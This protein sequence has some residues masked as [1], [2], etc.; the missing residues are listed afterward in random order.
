MTDPQQFDLIVVGSGPGGQKGAIAAAKSGARVAMVESARSVGGAC[1]HYGT[2]P[3][4]TLRQLA[5]DWSRAD[6]LERSQKEGQRALPLNELKSRVESVAVQLGATVLEQLERNG[7]R[8]LRG[9]GRFESPNEISVTTPRGARKL[10]RAEKILLA[11]GSTPRSLEGI[12]VDHEHV[13]D[14]DSVLSLS[15]LPES[16][17]VLGGGVIACEYA[18]MFACMG[19][20]VTILDRAPRPLGFL[21][22]ELSEGFVTAFEAMGGVYRAGCSPKGIT[23]DGFS[24]NMVTLEDGSFVEGEKVMVALGRTGVTREL[25]LEKAG[26]APNERGLLDV[27]E[28]LRTAVPHIYAVGDLI[29]PPAL[30]T[31]AMEQGRHAAEH[32]M[33]ATP[34]ANPGGLPVGIYTIPDIATIGVSELEGEDGRPLV[35][36][37]AH[38]REVAR[39]LINGDP[40]GWLRLIVEPA[41]ERIVGV[42]I[43]GEGATD[44]IH[45]GQLAIQGRQ[46][47][48]DLIEN[49][50]NFPTLTEAYRVAALDAKT[51]LSD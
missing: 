3:S 9:R 25:D 34:K 22:P 37:I 24:V 16:L 5:L 45:V 17:V 51:R 12:P 48:D 31:T 44:L 28:S 1:V 19:S 50:F 14:S 43:I 47:L 11:T 7:V 10:L 13:V 49:V 40:E 18:S 41:G 21:S 20:R 42:Q 29:G 6:R 8:V 35:E 2:I 32:A 36:G 4:K 26:L 27:D 30:A 23:W 46:T 39:S 33:G 15:Y 38:F